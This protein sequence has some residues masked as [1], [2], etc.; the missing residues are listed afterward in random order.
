M[1]A[2]LRRRHRIVWLVLGLLP[3]ALVMA[4]AARPPKSL[5]ASDLPAALDLMAVATTATAIAES[6]GSIAGVD[7]RMAVYETGPGLSLAL[8][9]LVE[10]PYPDVLAYWTAL[11]AEASLPSPA[12]LLGSIAG[13]RSQTLPLPGVAP[14]ADGYLTLYSLAHGQVLGSVSL[15][16]IPAR[17]E[18]VE[19]ALGSGADPLA[20]DLAGGS[21]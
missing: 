14:G 1:I 13:G 18:T 4:L 8:E 17:P 5:F 12:Y 11:P 7:V 9:P 6:T 15:P 10:L 21:P 3:I 2:P 16:A 19:P 20:G